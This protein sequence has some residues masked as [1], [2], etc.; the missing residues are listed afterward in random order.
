MTNTLVKRFKNYFK[1]NK[2]NP[3]VFGTKAVSDKLLFAFSMACLAVISLVQLYLVCWMLYSSVKDDIDMFISLFGLPKILRWENYKNVF[4]LI[5]VEIYVTGKGYVSY[6]L[7]VLVRNSIVYALLTPVQG[8]FVGNF[9]AY[10]MS[11]YRFK[12]RD[13]FLK[14]N[15]LIMILPIVGSLPSSLKVNYALGRYDN[16]LMM[17]VTGASPFGGMGLLIQMG[18][19]DAIPK[20]MMEAA[21]IDGAGHFQTFFRIHVPLMLPTIFFYYILAVFGTWN[22]YMTPL[23]WL[24]SM[25]N[26]ALGI[27][28][29]QYDSAKYAA[30]LPQVLA[31]FV[32]MSIP[33]TIFYLTTQKLMISRMVMTGLKG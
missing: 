23:V 15:Y 30:T 22:D 29:F 1:R 8:V 3:G 14:I 13:L 25:P 26:V 7:P 33:T 18:F 2:L 27:Y 32:L 9:T 4:K 24:P 12:G 6:G 11:K 16:F 28:Q 17:C 10:I 31:A 5:R 19:Y 21:Q 20:E